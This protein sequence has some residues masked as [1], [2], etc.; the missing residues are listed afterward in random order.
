[1]K[2]KFLNEKFILPKSETVNNFLAFIC[3][4]DSSTRFKR[5]IDEKI[6]CKG[7]I[8]WIDP[9]FQKIHLLRKNGMMPFSLFGRK[10]SAT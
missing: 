5:N 2:N 8:K 9:K 1:M 4:L 6:R 10:Y 7:R 3:S